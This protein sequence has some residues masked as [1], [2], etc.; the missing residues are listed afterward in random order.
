MKSRY[1]PLKS[2][3]LNLALGL[4]L[5][6]LVSCGPSPA[7]T[8]ARLQGEAASSASTLDLLQRTLGSGFD[9]GKSLKRSSCVN[10]GSFAYS[11]SNYSDLSYLRDL[12][13]EELLDETGLE[14]YAKLD[15]FGLV[16]AKVTGGITSTFQKTDDS[17]AFIV[18][19]NIVGKSAV[20]Q[21]LALT[22]IGISA[23]KTNDPV[24]FREVCGDQFVEQVQLGA[25]LYIGVKY[26][27]TSEEDKEKLKIQLKGS[28]LWGLIKWTKTWTKE[29]RELLKN[30]RVKIDTYQIG[31]NTKKLDDLRKSIQT[32]SCSA[33]DIE[34]CAASLDKL[35]EYA[36]KDFPGQL[37]G[38][39]I[40]GN[41]NAGPA[42]I[43]VV[44]VPYNNQPFFN[45]DT[46]E[47]VTIDVGPSTTID[48]TF[49]P[50]LDKLSRM[51]SDLN[52]DILRRK[53][54]IEFNLTPQELAQIEVGR[55]EVE[56]LLEQANLLMEKTCQPARGDSSLRAECI[57]KVGQ[58]E[59]KAQKALQPIV[60]SSRK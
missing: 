22:D 18:K 4:C 45:K 40:S 33:N 51:Q 55:R 34:K 35:M 6:T 14:A 23:L 43:G 41:P 25:E 37:N 17:S 39:D 53:T 13:Y 29:E 52:T 50:Y 1:A 5:V 42:I 46:G 59:V 58:L 11:G 44:T 24:H 20:L 30:V 57:A 54:L 7:G 15:L 28:A 3:F 9:S 8:T 32:D 49:Q 48:T 2:V 56:G 16:T 31:G 27:F 26:Y 19:S 10:A 21:D 12:S 60:I 47:F 38:M 36:T